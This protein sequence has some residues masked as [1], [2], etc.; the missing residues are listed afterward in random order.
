MISYLS[1]HVNLFIRTS[2]DESLIDIRM[3]DPLTSLCLASSLA[4]FVDFSCKLFQG[5]KSI[6]KSAI[7]SS[8]ENACL[9][10]IAADVRRLSSDIEV[11]ESHPEALR[12][13]AIETKRVSDELLGVLEDLRIKEKKTKWRSFLLAVKEIWNKEKIA[14]ISERLSKL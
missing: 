8:E 1:I 10:L 9:H 3:L 5:T 11:L 13:L 14:E 12:V 6:Y 2:G 7:G 4:Q